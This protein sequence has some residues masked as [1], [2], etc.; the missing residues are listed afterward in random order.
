MTFLVPKTSGCGVERANTPILAT[1]R[2]YLEEWGGSMEGG[3]GVEE[4]EVERGRCGGGV[5][6]FPRLHFHF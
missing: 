1:A 2:L 6:S 4:E 5:M 3:G